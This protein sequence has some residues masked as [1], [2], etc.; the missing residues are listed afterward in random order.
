MITKEYIETNLL[1]KNGGLNSNKTKHILETPEELYKIFYNITENPKC[2]TCGKTITT[3]LNFKKGYTKFCSSKCVAQNKNISKKRANT[4]KKVYAKNK[5]EI[6]AKKKSTSM[7]NYG[8]DHPMKSI[9][10]KNS[11]KQTFLLK[12]GV[13]NPTYIPSHNLK[14]TETSKLKYGTEHPQQSEF[15]RKKVEATCLE[16]FGTKT[17]LMN[18]EQKYKIKETNILKYGVENPSQSELIKLKKEYTYIENYGSKHYLSSNIRRIKMEDNQSWIPLDQK[19]N[20]ELYSRQVWIETRKQDI[21]SLKHSEKRGTKGY[22]LDHKFSIL[23]GFKNNILPSIIGNIRNLEFIP[24]Q[25]NL[26][27][28]KKCSIRLDELMK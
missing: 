26:S 7:K 15:V 4:Y 2:Q 27:K 16:K 24:Y 5:E 8:V 10:I 28:G 3:F 21:N 1:M 17:N 9:E 18:E 6:L 25:E 23:E 11:Q 14:V 22:H 12:Y 13:E 19:T 20:Y